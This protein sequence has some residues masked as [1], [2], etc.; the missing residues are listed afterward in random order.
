MRVR[1]LIPAD[2]SA[3][4]EL[5][6]EAYDLHP[7]AFTST[8]RERSVLGMDWWEARL[9]D[10]NSHVVGVFDEAVLVGAAGVTFQSRRKVIHKA[11]LFGMY[12]REPFRHRGCGGQLVD[13]VLAHARSRP[14]VTVV[15]LTVTQGNEIAQLLY[16]RCGFTSYGVEPY[17]IATTEGFLSKVHMW[18]FVR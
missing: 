14:E 15:Q 10:A 13:A 1:S 16:Q 4:R 11:S 5:M 7:D 9:S 6:L 8:R 2:S 12:V 18:R 3:Y 17:A